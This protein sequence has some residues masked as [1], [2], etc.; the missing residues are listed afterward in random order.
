MDLQQIYYAKFK[1]YWM[2]KK[3]ERMKLEV[4]EKYRNHRLMRRSME[5]IKIVIRSK[6][7]IEV[8]CDVLRSNSY[9]LFEYLDASKMSPKISKVIY[10]VN[11]YRLSL[12]RKYFRMLRENLIS[13]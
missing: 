11:H 2:T 5:S 13:K 1:Q 3:L 10:A 9:S 7:Q 8:A 12:M 6:R 4:A